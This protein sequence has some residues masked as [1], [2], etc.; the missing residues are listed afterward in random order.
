MGDLTAGDLTAHP[1][2]TSRLPWMLSVVPQFH[3]PSLSLSDEG[4]TSH[5][6]FGVC[7]WGRPSQKTLPPPPRSRA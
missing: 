2:P 1:P 3:K 5:E 6:S 4:G 7:S